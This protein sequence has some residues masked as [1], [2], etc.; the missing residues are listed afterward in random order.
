[1][2]LALHDGEGKQSLHD[3][4]VNLIEEISQHI[5]LELNK[6]SLSN[7]LGDFLLD[8]GPLVHAKIKEPKIRAINVWIE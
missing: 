1:M 2:C 5:I 4:K 8:H 3:R 6:Q 7:S